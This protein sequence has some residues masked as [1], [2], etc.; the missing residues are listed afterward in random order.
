[1]GLENSSLFLGPWNTS[2]ARPTSELLDRPWSSSRLGEA[3]APAEAEQFDRTAAQSDIDGRLVD[4]RF[5]KN[6]PSWF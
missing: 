4:P 5:V 6:R 1:M 3:A 2:W